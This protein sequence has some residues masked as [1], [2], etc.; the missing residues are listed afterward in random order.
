[1]SAVPMVGLST[2]EM[3]AAITEIQAANPDQRGDQTEAVDAPSEDWRSDWD[4]DHIA[5]TEEDRRW[6][7]WP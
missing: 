2:A 4:A 5:L 3:I 6:R 7:Q 1:M